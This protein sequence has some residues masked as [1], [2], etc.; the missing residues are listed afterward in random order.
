MSGK[1]PIVKV[2][3][4]LAVRPKAKQKMDGRAR[5]ARDSLGDALVDLMHERPFKSIT[6]QDVLDRA[7][8]GRSTFYTHYRDKDDLFMSDVE[9]FWEMMSSMLERN[10]ETSM[11][12]APVRELFAHIA[13]VKVFRDALAASGKMHDVM[14]LGQGQFARAI[15]RRLVK[16]TSA[17]GGGPI[18]FAAT[19]HALAGALFSSLMWWIDRGMPGSAA[20]MDEAFHRFVWSGVNA[21]AQ[22]PSLKPAKSASR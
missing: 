6:V 15:E 3:P 7:G 21:S 4:A 5:R 12:V 9:E 13:D 18:Q 17:N 22:V 1:K 19:A 10:G 16:L 11:R 2:G 14:E 20:E 8:V